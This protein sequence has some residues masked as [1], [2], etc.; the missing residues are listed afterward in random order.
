MSVVE[1]KSTR[2]LGTLIIWVGRWMPSRSSV[3]R[4]FLVEVNLLVQSLVELTLPLL[5]SLLSIQSPTY[6]WGWLSLRRYRALS[7]CLVR[8][9][10]LVDPTRKLFVLT[11]EIF[12]M[13]LYARALPPSNFIWSWLRVRVLISNK[14]SRFP[15][16]D[17]SWCSSDL[18]FGDTR[19]VLR[20]SLQLRLTSILQLTLWQLWDYLSLLIYEISIIRI[21]LIVR[22]S[23]LARRILPRALPLVRRRHFLL[24]VPPGWLDIVLR[25]PISGLIWP[26]CWH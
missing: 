11:Y 26:P 20:D 13:S 7:L 21:N 19:S 16:I 14:Q 2:L 18:V 22:I 25:N 23:T 17:S 5:L 12:P 1:A 15:W 4:S 24:L 8:R 3:R 6:L 10:W 9:G